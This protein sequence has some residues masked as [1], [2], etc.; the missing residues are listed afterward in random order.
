MGKVVVGLSRTAAAAGA[1]RW[2]VERAVERAMALDI[3]TA[4][5]IPVPIAAPVG[6]LAVVPDRE[7]LVRAARREQ[8]QLLRQVLAE[9]G[10]PP[11]IHR[12]VACGDPFHV[13][14]QAA[15]DAELVVLGPSKRRL[16]PLAKRCRRR[17][18]CPVVVVA[19][20]HPE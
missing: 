17:L 16:L 1:L 5:P 4:V 8:D 6:T 12:T 2:A 10:E 19:D 15:A 7:R 9:V 18:D 11:E 14:Q 13:L 20:G 3:V